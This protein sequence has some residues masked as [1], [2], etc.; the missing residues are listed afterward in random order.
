MQEFIRQFGEMYKHQADKEGWN[1]NQ[2]KVNQ[3]VVARFVLPDGRVLSG[4][5]NLNL[6]QGAFLTY[7]NSSPDD[8]EARN[9]A[10][11]DALLKRMPPLSELPSIKDAEAVLFLAAASPEEAVNAALTARRFGFSS[12][13]LQTNRPEIVSA[14]IRAASGST[15]KIHAVASVFRLSSEDVLPSTDQDRNLLGETGPE[16]VGAMMAATRW[17]NYFQSI[18]RSTFP[19]PTEAQVAGPVHGS[20]APGSASLAERCGQL[21]ELAAV[22][23]LAGIALTDVAPIG[24]AGKRS[25]AQ[26]GGYDLP[27]ILRS[28][29]GFTPEQR[30]VF[31]QKEGVDPIDLIPR[32]LRFSA[33]LRQP[34]FLDDNARGD[35]SVYD[36]R[37]NPVTGFPEKLGA[38]DSFRGQQVVTALQNLKADIRK[39]S[40]ALPV[41]IT[42]LPYYL[43]NGNGVPRKEFVLWSDTAPLPPR[44]GESG[45]LDFGSPVLLPFAS[46][47]PTDEA[48]VRY[49]GLMVQSMINPKVPPG[50][51]PRPSTPIPPY[52]LDL[53]T[54]PVTDADALLA[55]WFRPVE[56]Q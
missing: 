42:R 39:A 2:V 45:A 37:D 31:L 50:G 9:K 19:R 38:W 32:N 21:A 14:A 17:K 41:W 52:A 15:L 51:A 13:Y 43:P 36:G 12:L 40:P 33:D 5:S 22:P 53:S 55:K 25:E 44:F 48:E 18:S 47:R 54:L 24:Y 46:P 20:F 8:D 35:S 29:L 28:E 23:G 6:G 34:F 1:L 30:R 7:K 10:Q 49:A 27:F 16:S 3:N 56:A 11:R 26:Y 4:H